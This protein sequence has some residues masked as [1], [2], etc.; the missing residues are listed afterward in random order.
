[1]STKGVVVDA[2]EIISKDWAA[3]T[4][5]EIQYLV[6]SNVGMK[7]EDIADVFGVDKNAVLDRFR[8]K[9]VAVQVVNK[10]KQRAYDTDPVGYGR[11]GIRHP[12]SVSVNDLTDYLNT[13]EALAARA[14]NRK[15]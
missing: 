1:T 3:V 8:K 2:F 9:P 6:S 13:P 12:N 5:E 15:R 4:Q 10:P 7:T 14:H 11:V